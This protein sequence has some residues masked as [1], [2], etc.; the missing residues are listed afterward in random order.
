[1]SETIMELQ[2][3]LRKADTILLFWS[4]P[5]V[6]CLIRRNSQWESCQHS[7]TRLIDYC[8]NSPWIEHAGK[9]SKN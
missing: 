5:L 4:G 9:V 3:I 6:L 1:M 8:S 2:N 7:I